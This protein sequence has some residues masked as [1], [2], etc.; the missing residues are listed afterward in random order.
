MTPRPLWPLHPQPYEWDVLD[1]WLKRLADAYGVSF[2]VFCRHALG[3]SREEMG[4]L[5]DKPSEETLRT[6]EAGTGVSIERLRDMTTL[7][8][9]QRC[10][11]ALERFMQADP[12][13]FAILENWVRELQVNRP[14][15]DFHYLLAS[16]DTASLG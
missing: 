13:G 8:V 16:T 15:P 10:T 11:Q 6:L 7:R 12:Q 14:A 9:I 2:R 1:S 5:R 3:L 4:S